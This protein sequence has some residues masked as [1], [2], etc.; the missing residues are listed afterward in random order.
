MRRRLGIR[1]L[2]VSVGG[3]LACVAWSA[4]AQEAFRIER[5]EIT[6]VTLLKASDAQA[7]VAPSVGPNR[8]VTDI[9]KAIAALQTAYRQRGFGAV[10]VTAPEQELTGGIVRLD[11]H[12]SRLAKVTVK[13]NLHFD[14]TNIRASLPGLQQ[15]RSPNLR[16]M[17]DSI[18]LANDNPAKQVAV[19]L[20]ANEADGGVDATVEVTDYNPL[21]VIASLDNTGTSSSGK[22][23][24][25]VALQHANL[26]GRDQVGT[27]AYTTSPDSPSGVHVNLYSAGYRI[28]V[29]GLGDSLDLLYGK[30]SVNVPGSSPTLGGVL[31]FTGKGQVFGLHWN[32]FLPRDGET[33]SKI[34]AGIDRR[35]TDS[36]CD[37]DGVAVDTDAPTP[38]IAACVPYTTQPLSVTYSSQR[39][40]TSMASDYFIG[41]SRNFATGPRRTNID[42]RVDRYSYLTPGNRDTSDSFVVLRAGGSY[43]Q[44]L[45]GGWQARIVG[46]AQYTNDAL[47][48]SERLG[49]TGAQAVRGFEERSVTADS[50]AFVN[51]ELTTP[52]LAEKLYLPGDL[53]ALAFVDAGRGFNKHTAA[54][55]VPGKVSVASFGAGL[56]AGFGRDVTVRLDVARVA[57]AGD[58]TTESQ[59]D[60]N[61]HLAASFAY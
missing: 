13:G 36:S 23:R 25:G 55:A 37:V 46:N 56:R 10:T 42:G 4:G 3:A 18:Q 15:G 39:Q 52:N 22:W 59:G 45:G 61:A 12:E 34:I 31:G 48:L 41:V 50:G 49:L 20:A 29:Y 60:W 5:F 30:S 54:T 58:S 28:P 17:S 14:E 2:K 19:S 27:L 43:L 26:F 21:R 9:S 35:E 1:L 33:S 11:V 44:G 24:T 53:H 7:L 38:P 57:K 32:H 40:G 8:G 47:L 51:A 16:Q 6:G